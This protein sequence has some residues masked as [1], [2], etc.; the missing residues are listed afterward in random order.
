M[1]KVAVCDDVPVLAEV[2]ENLILE[3]D[4]SLFEIDVFNNP[5]RLIE[6]LKSNTYDLFILD[7]EFGNISGIEIAE[8]IR[9]NN[10]TCPIIFVTSFN[11]YMER[12]FK[13]N[14]FD[15]ILKP[16]TKDK[17]YPALNRTINYLNIDDSKFT[18]TFNKIFYSL[19]HSEIIYFEKNKRRVLIHTA[20]DTYETLLQTNALLS[21]INDHFVQVHTSYI[22]NARHIK[23]V[24]SNSITANLDDTR[25]VEIPMSRKFIDSAKKQILMKIRELM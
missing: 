24:S 20:S 11:E 16:V 4:S 1:L 10:L 5:F 21:K 2:I 14:T 23:K 7:I 6:F 9:E 22:V 25:T 12:A 17:L 15:Y 19:S 3:Y 8:A 13:V 18:F